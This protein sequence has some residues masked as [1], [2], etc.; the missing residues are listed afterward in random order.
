M[1]FA[2]LFKGW[3]R[4]ENPPADEI[5]SPLPVAPAPTP[6]PATPAYSPPPVAAPVSVAPMP[7]QLGEDVEIPLGPILEKLPQDLRAKMTMRIDELGNA[8]MAFATEQILSQLAQGTVRITFGQL[9]EAAPQLFNVAEEYDS[10][11]VTLPLNLL[12]SRLNPN[13]LPRN[14]Q[15]KQLQVPQ[16]IKGPFGAK[17]EGV[18]FATS[19]LKAPPSST[20][21]PRMTAPE[22]T[23]AKFQARAVA[24]PPPAYARPA[25]PAPSPIPSKPIPFP[26]APSVPQ[27]Q[28]PPPARPP[29]TAPISFA[30]PKPV[31][32]VT[33]IA[34]AVS[35]AVSS[36]TTIPVTLAALSEKWPEPLREEIAQANLANA[37]VILPM[38]QI[39]PAMKRGRVVFPWQTLRAWMSPASS[40]ASPN[41]GIEL[42]L[43]LK[44]VV[45]LFLERHPP[46]RP[47]L[48]VSVDRSIPDLFFG[49]PS[50]EMEAPVAAPVGEAPPPA[51]I[52]V[53]RPSPVM[54][55]M[56][57]AVPSA[58]PPLQHMQPAQASDTN[59]FIAAETLKAPAVDQSVYTRSAISDT[60]VKRRIA[61][62][63]E[64]VERAMQ[65]PGVAG[66][67]IT[68]PDGLKVAARLPAELN[69]D[70]IAAFIPQI[71]ERLG[72]ST[73]ELRMGALN[74]LRF[75]VGNVPW[76]IFR[77][78]AIY[79]AAF[80]RPGE[81]LPTPQLAQLAAELDRKTQ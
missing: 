39:E 69:P 8:T 72:Q 50:P 16:E 75:T 38:N 41:D 48:R 23:T 32:P 74:N 58:T 40:A 55:P 22:T 34:P 76:K 42:V 28:P 61:T 30:P 19:L 71:F 66:A 51:A 53:Q 52:P 2:G 9:R 44:V 25:A 68:L 13:L 12:L 73:R 10:L 65:I 37:Q 36:S 5:P 29:A 31:A 35:P 46:M 57:A 24:P 18:S 70:T 20:P 3:M 47:P 4:R 7:T 21:P 1:N 67:V 49:F 63:N 64:I 11:P 27:T 80:G 56:R 62:P 54:P 77:I 6:Q 81:R 15:Q 45:P 33:P 17:A 26:S 78:N 43:P 79:F 59:Y 14:P 60:E